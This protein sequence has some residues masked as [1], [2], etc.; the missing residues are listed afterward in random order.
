MIY[1]LYVLVLALNASLSG[2]SLALPWSTG[3]LFVSFNLLS[4]P[5]DILLVYNSLWSLLFPMLSILVFANVA[6]LSA[7][8]IFSLLALCPFRGSAKVLRVLIASFLSLASTLS[9]AVIFTWGVLSLSPPGLWGGRW[10]SGAVSFTASCA[11]TLVLLCAR[12]SPAPTPAL[13]TVTPALQEPLPHTQG[14]KQH[15]HYYP[16]SSQNNST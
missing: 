2:V 6:L 3:G 11:L 13:P 5:V 16:H 15:E 4:Q 10:G 7:A 9:L 1:S 12:P 14:A 8:V